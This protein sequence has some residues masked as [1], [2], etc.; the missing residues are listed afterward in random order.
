MKNI[1]IIGASSGI[2]NALASLYAS[3]GNKVAVMARRGELLHEL[4]QEFP[5]QIISFSRDIASTNAILDV[6]EEIKKEWQTL[7]LIVNCAAIVEDNPNLGSA[8]EL[9][10]IGVNVSGFTVISG[11]AYN[12]FK[13]QQYGSYA[14]IT[15]VFG[16]RGRRLAPAYN[17]SKAYQ[18]NYLEALRQKSSNENLNSKFMDIRAGFVK[19]RMAPENAMHLPVIREDHAAKLIARAINKGNSV[20]FIP[21]Y[22]YWFA[23]LLRLIPNRIYERL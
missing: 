11:W 9:N 6:L 22:W 13:A 4:Q 14:A 17:A 19:T 18:I 12:L 8:I 1:V 15:S 10:T 20:S 3:K 2:G 7:D 21:F 16:I 23:L 5:K